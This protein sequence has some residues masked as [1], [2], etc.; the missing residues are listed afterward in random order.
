[1]ELIKISFYFV[2]TLCPNNAFLC[3]T[4]VFQFHGVPFIKCYSKCLYY[5][6]Y[7]Q[8]VFSC[9]NESKTIHHFLLYQVQWN[10][11]R[12]DK[13]ES[14]YIL[15]GIHPVWPA[16][17]WR[18]FFQCALLNFLFKKLGVHKYENLCLGLQFSSI[19]VYFCANIS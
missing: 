7:V 6:C 8:W 3:C 4:K 5:W 16:P 10:F 1:M 15:T 12:S 2:L 19:D 17:F 9:A 18:C 14:I 11:M 13:Y